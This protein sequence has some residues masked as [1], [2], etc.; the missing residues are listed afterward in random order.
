[1]GLVGKRSSKV[2]IK[3]KIPTPPL[4]S[5]GSKNL[6]KLV[7]FPAVPHPPCTS[8]RGQLKAQSHLE[9]Q[10]SVKTPLEDDTKDAH[11]GAKA[12]PLQSSIVQ[13]HNPR[14]DMY[15]LLLHRELCGSSIPGDPYTCFVAQERERAQACGDD[16]SP[17]AEPPSS[18]NTDDFPN[19]IRVFP[20]AV[21][22]SLPFPTE[23]RDKVENWGCCGNSF[24][25]KTQSTQVT[26][27]FL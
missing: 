11:S 20:G 12:L 13:G 14:L 15:G 5:A 24:E 18:R 16:S 27:V 7:L 26:R 19:T 22:A 9:M 25:K 4:S 21:R 8:G 17:A 2:H 23:R 6:G 3:K 1:M 10:D